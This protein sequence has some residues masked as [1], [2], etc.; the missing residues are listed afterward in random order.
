MLNMSQPLVHGRVFPAEELA[1]LW[2]GVAASSKWQSAFLSFGL[3]DE[4]DRE[5]VQRLSDQIQEGPAEFPETPTKK[6]PQEGEGAAPLT[7]ENPSKI[8]KRVNAGRPADFG[9]VPKQSL[10]LRSCKRKGETNGDEKPTKTKK[11]PNVEAEDLLD[12][13]SDDEKAE[14]GVL[15][16][17]GKN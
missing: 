1:K 4:L 12:L 17:S 13:E 10:T 14:I 16:C 9:Q 2:D 3:Q 5:V 15:V 11:S 6:A 7:P 8:P